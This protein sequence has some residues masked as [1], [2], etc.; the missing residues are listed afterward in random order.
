MSAF[1][2]RKPYQMNAHWCERCGQVV[3]ECICKAKEVVLNGGTPATLGA[4]EPGKTSDDSSGSQTKTNAGERGG[5]RWT[6]SSN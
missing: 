1:P 2:R 6:K 4:S 3:Q 5:E